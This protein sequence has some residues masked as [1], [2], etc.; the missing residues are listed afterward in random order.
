VADEAVRVPER[1]YEAYFFD[2][3]GTIYLGDDLL[4][5]A[6]RLVDELRSR[7]KAVRFLSNNPTKDPQQYA[8]K[9]ARLGL[10]TPIEEI[11]NTT[12]T[13]TRWLV[14][15]HPD[16]VVFPISEA[17]L[18]RAFEAA[19]IRMSDDPAEI[20]IV[21]ASYDRGFSYEKLQIAFDAIW[22]HKRARLVGTNP[23]RFCPFPGGRGEPDCAAVI[24]AVEA[25]TGTTCEA[26]LGKPNPAMLHAALKGLDVD[27]SDCVMVGDRLSTD[28]R[29][30]LD[31]GTAAA[32][33]LTGETK[34]DDLRTLAPEDVPGIVVD[35]IDR[36]LPL[37]AWAEA[38]WSE[39]ERV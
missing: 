6:K 3:D 21:V 29:M 13:M 37:D 11:V 1:L 24:A 35:R 23:D 2:L 27:M 4:P 32:L 16:A 25:C 22:F 30:G 5:G 34:A 36:L 9:L 15:N 39:E 28:I 19:G 12:V 18:K 31:A 20:D 14:E 26:N 7:G 17:P 8:D 38:G 33:V 10:P